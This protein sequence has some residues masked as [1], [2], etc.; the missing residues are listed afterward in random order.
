ME[1]EVSCHPLWDMAH[2]SAQVGD[3]SQRQTISSTHPL[4]ISLTHTLSLEGRT[5]EGKDE[6]E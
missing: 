4:L 1:W 5:R 2:M 3:I 6:L